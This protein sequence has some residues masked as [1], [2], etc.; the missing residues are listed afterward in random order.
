[1]RVTH[2]SFEKI[3]DGNPVKLTETGNI[4]EVMSY[5]RK[6]KG[7]DVRKLSNDTYFRLRD[8]VEPYKV[9]NV[10]DYGFSINSETGE[11]LNKENKYVERDGLFYPVQFYKKTTNRFQGINELRRTFKK[12]RN[13]IN[14]NVSAPECCKFCTLTYAENMTDTKQFCD[15]FR[16]FN[17]RFK[18]YVYNKFGMK[19]EYIAVAEPQGRGAWHMHVIY[20]FNGAAP[21]IHYSEYSRLWGLGSVD[22]ETFKD[23]D[24]LGAYFSAYLS[25]ITL[26][27]NTEFNFDLSDKKIIN[28]GKDKKRVIKGGRL[29][30]YPAKFN[31]LRTSRGIKR[32]VITEMTYSEA[33]DI[34]TKNISDDLKY[35]NTLEDCCTF[36]SCIDVD[37]HDDGFKFHNTIWYE[38]YNV[39]RKSKN[40]PFKPVDESVPNNDNQLSLSDDYDYQYEHYFDSLANRLE[41]DYS[42]IDY[43]KYKKL[44]YDVFDLYKLFTLEGLKD[45]NRDTLL[46]NFI[47]MVLNDT[48]SL[49][50]LSEG[51]I[52]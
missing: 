22:L 37:C 42:C 21:Y 46:H 24:N 3:L 27:E 10:S 23:I 48:E 49:V 43:A 4:Y 31:I 19:Y 13:I 45:F 1:M 20:I 17:Q 50:I 12:I 30:M 36:R 33:K 25:N 28:K 26:D 51:V 35:T 15:D 29:S 11:L 38:Y 6:S 41:Y 14:C 7:S 16:K 34:I 47:E 18:R 5:T 2:R 44:G 8:F 40:K 52:E 39:V 32:P 9:E